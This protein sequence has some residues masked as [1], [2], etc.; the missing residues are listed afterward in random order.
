MQL[1]CKD[2]DIYCQEENKEADRSLQYN[3]PP[4][5][6]IHVRKRTGLSER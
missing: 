3:D 1:Q 6:L 4:G 5:S 2:F